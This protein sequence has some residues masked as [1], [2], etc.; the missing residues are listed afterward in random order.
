MSWVAQNPKTISRKF[1]SQKFSKRESRQTMLQCK[2]PTM[3]P[4]K[5]W[6]P[7][8]NRPVK[9]IKNFQEWMQHQQYLKNNHH[10]VISSGWLDDI[11]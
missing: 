7:K 5:G 4:A 3:D 1:P 6:H 10:L 8:S 2:H 9:V 11:I